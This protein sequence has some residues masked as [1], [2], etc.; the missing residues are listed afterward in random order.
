L[1]KKVFKKEV[2]HFRGV[3]ESV[4]GAIEVRYGAK[5]RARKRKTRAIAMNFERVFRQRS[6]VLVVIR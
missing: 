2:Y 4:F 5:I 1:C 6:F 3:A